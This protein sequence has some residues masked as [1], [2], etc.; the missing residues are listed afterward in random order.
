MALFNAKIG[1]ASS[2]AVSGIFGL[3]LLNNGDTMSD[4]VTA[5]SIDTYDCTIMVGDKTSLSASFGG[6]A[7]SLAY[8]YIRKDGTCE[9]G[10]QSAPYSLPSDVS[11]YSV[12]TFRGSS[13]STLTL[14]ATLS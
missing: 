9:K 3:S 2:G 6:S 5:L 7:S 10:S 14:T 8:L 1:G 12:L 4:S 11:N 13:G